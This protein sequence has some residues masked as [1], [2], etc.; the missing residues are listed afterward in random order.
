MIILWVS[1]F[2]ITKKK[3]IID[4]N[5]SLVFLLMFFCSGLCFQDYTFLNDDLIWLSFIYFIRFINSSY[6][7]DK[8]DFRISLN[9]LYIS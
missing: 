8:L 4:S 1:S 5:N 3:Y 6:V 7:F 2:D 9:Y